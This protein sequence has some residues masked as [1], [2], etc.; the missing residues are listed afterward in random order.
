MFKRLA[1]T[2]TTE[3]ISRKMTEDEFMQLPKD[4]RK[5][6]L[7]NGEAKE[8]PT[9]FDHD[10]IGIN[11]ILLLAPY[12]KGRGFMTSGQA[13]FRMADDNIRCPD[14]SYTRK[15]RVPGGKPPPTFGVVAPDLCVEIISPSENRFDMMQK[16]QEY[17][18]SG[19]QQVW[20]V[21]PET[22]TVTVYTTPAE[23]K[24]YAAED[25]LSCGDILP[26]FTCLVSD[27]FEQ[28]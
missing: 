21:F 25:Q 7:V 17:F 26:G 22:K 1:M 9:K 10:A 15:E 27:L 13:G 20:H 28:Q 8:V 2:V 19:A 12:A 4:G 11:L 5:W 6:E 23:T 16:V 24:D 14:V 18:E 3:R